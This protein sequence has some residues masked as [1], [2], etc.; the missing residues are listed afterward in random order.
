MKILITGFDP[1]DK[2]K[3]N[4]AYEAVKLLPDI[5]AD[6]EIIKLEIPTVFGKGAF[7]VE[8]TIEK[9]CP[10]YV[11]CVGQAGG[12]SSI[13]VEKVAI[14]FVDARIADNDGN[15]PINTSIVPD[16]A[17]AYFSSLP[18]RA[19][20]ENMRENGIPANIS[21]TAGTFVCNEVMYRLLHLIDTKYHHIKG[22]F[23]HVPYTTAQ[24]ASKPDGTASMDEKTIAEGLEYA[25]LAIVQNKEHS[26]GHMGTT[27]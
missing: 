9:H 7:L 15:Q 22:G 24:A 14:N 5:I 16:G 17:T 6:A 18:I 21:Y 1:F 26:S 23:I 20:V 2:E 27:H 12:R 4:P 3:L 11:I 19:M 10:D 8:Q 25:I 13:T